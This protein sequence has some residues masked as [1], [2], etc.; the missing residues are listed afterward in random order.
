MNVHYHV[1]GQLAQERQRERLADARRRQLRRELRNG[2]DRRVPR[3]FS[4]VSAITRRL[5]AA[6]AKVGR[7][8]ARVPDATWPARPLSPGETPAE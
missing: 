2:Q 7:T 1:T 3:T 4:A 5:A 8:T 6:I